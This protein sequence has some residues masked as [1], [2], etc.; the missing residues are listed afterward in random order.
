MQ[1]FQN[2]IREYQSH[3]ESIVLS[4]RGGRGPG[5]RPRSR[6][7][8][9]LFSRALFGFQEAFELWDGNAKA[10][11][12]HFAG[13]AGLRPARRWRK[14]TSTWA[15]RCLEAD[16][17]CTPSLRR[18]ILAA[19]RERDARQQ[20]LKNVKRIAG[21]LG[22]AGHRGRRR[23][24]MFKSVRK[25]TAP[26]RRADGDQRKR[27]RPSPP[28]AD[29]GQRAGRKRPRPPASATEHKTSPQES[30][31]EPKRENRNAEK[32]SRSERKPSE[33]A[34]G[35]S[36]K[37]AEE[38]E[39]YIARIGLAAAKIDENAFDS[40]RT[41]D[42]LRTGSSRSA[43]CQGTVATGNGAGSKFLCDAKALR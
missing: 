34:D 14:T 15:L 39:A 28:R 33:S 22:R 18:Q 10:Q 8:I 21:G 6:A 24:A 43:H 30:R 11:G 4:S 26:C 31:L 32:A 29:G 41:A 5:A 35:R 23:V 9:R 40:P 2:A 25:A 37:E 16:D 42:R 38:Y 27:T 7:T 1:D 36:A 17:P 19:Q 12:R 3:S 20:R 13:Q